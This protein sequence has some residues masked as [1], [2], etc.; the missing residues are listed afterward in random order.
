M[1]R[2]GASLL[3]VS[4]WLEHDER[5]GN[6]ESETTSPNGQA[7]TNRRSPVTEIVKAASGREEPGLAIR[8]AHWNSRATSYDVDFGCAPIRIRTLDEVIALTPQQARVV[9]DSGTGT[10][11]TL[12][13]L[14]THLD[15]TALVI[16]LDFS[17]EMLRQSQQ[18][19]THPARP[20]AMVQADHTALP[21]RSASADVII[22]SF[23]LHHIPPSQQLRML[24]EF[25]R[26]LAD[27]GSL[28]I[29]DQVQADPPLD[30][31][32]MKTVIAQTFYPHLAEYDGIKKL[33]SYGEWPMQVHRLADLMQQAGFEFLEIHRINSIVA[34][35]G[36]MAPEPHQLA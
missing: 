16:G 22:S 15:S 23:T 24:R 31:A 35:L 4:S 5:S 33:S 26:V 18:R 7:A 34:V 9:I 13:R 8:Q 36:A 2:G 27:K 10:G 20:P 28:I 14:M 19:S 3:H 25:R 11:R 6:N 32:R 21:F 17:I 12:R 29:A 1:Q 30:P